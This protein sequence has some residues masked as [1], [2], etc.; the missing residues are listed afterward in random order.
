MTAIYPNV[1]PENNL[2]LPD[3]LTIK[4]GPA[5]LLSTFVLEGDKAARRLGIRLRLRH[6]FPE[7]VYVNEQQI[8]N[9]NWYPLAKM[10]DPGVSDLVPEN[11]YWISGEDEH[12]EIVLTPSGTDLLLAGN[13]I[14]ARSP[15]DVLWGTG[16][17]STLHDHRGS[18]EIDYRGGVLR[19]L[20]LDPPRFSRPGTLPTSQPA[21]QSLCGGA[22]AGELGDGAR[23]TDH[24]RKG[25][26][27]RL[28]IQA[29]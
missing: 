29:P 13:D 22:V 5:R 20:A 11:S 6:D 18:G 19:R 10:F 7:L 12:G 14:G 26:S 1:V 2:R 4:H 28:W 27:E 16:R 25:G 23:D 15:V 8:A 24:R 17:G 21:R 3:A 9:N